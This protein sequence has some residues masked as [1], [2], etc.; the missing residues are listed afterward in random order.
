[1]AI[2][3]LKALICS[4]NIAACK[5]VGHVLYGTYKTQYKGTALPISIYRSFIV[6]GSGS[7][8]TQDLAGESE[9]C[10]SPPALLWRSSEYTGEEKA[11]RGKISV[12]RAYN[13][14]H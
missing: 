3:G 12:D 8:F 6:L 13:Q 4:A 14:Q 11:Y 10:R 2:V 5:A 9:V 7:G 1:M